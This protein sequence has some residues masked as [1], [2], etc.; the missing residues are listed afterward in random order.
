ML[1]FFAF[2]GGMIAVP[3]VVPFQRIIAET[4]TDPTIK[5]MLWAAVE[6]IAKFAAAYIFALRTRFMDEPIDAMIYMIT[7]ALGFA[8]LENAFFLLKPLMLGDAM[9]SVVT[10]NLRFMGATLLHVVS[11]AAVGLFIAL[12]YFKSKLHKIVD[13][14]FGI[15]FAIALHTAFNLFIIRST[16]SDT[17]IIFAC[18]WAVVVLMILMFEKVKNINPPQV[19]L[20]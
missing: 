1:I 3:L 2:I 5:Y 19:Q 8:A 6:E 14:S 7:V 10:G 12:P 20:H 9:R 4:F 16:G 17:F 15:L 11:S 13:L 18:V